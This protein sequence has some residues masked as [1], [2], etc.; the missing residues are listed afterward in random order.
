M[1][2]YLSVIKHVAAVIGNSSS[3]IIEAP[4]LGIPTLNIG[5]RQKGRVTCDSIISCY[6]DKDSI[7]KGLKKVL[8]EKMAKIAKE[9]RNP[10]EKKK[11]AQSIFNVIKDYPLND[12]AQK[13]FYNL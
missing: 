1:K 2:R 3:G 6:S 7:R 5:D 9:V 10:Y 13:S 12:L 11:T 8:S 4:S